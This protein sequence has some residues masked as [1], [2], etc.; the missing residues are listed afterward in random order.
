MTGNIMWGSHAS[1]MLLGHWLLAGRAYRSGHML[2]SGNF[3]SSLAP[4]GGIGLLF[5][6]YP[7]SLPADALPFLGDNLV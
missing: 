5:C 6:L 4:A 2:P 3:G 7:G 1:S